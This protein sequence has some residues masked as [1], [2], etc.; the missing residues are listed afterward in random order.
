LEESRPVS[1]AILEHPGPWTEEDFLAFGPTPNRIELIDG[2]LLVSSAPRMS[3]QH[4]AR[5][6][7]NSLEPTAAASGLRVF[8]AINIRLQ[9][10]RIVVPDVVVVETNDNSTVADVAVVRFICEVVSPNNAARD[11]VLKRELYA[12][13]GI[14]W[15]L[16]ADEERDDTVTLRLY[17]LSGGRYIEHAAAM[18]GMVLAAVASFD[19][20]VD[21][22]DLPV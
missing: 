17:R 22:T 15:Y 12:E 6:L 9:K 2:D 18:N 8:E 19:V 21:T 20:R 7:A 14:E 1:V 10:G 5:R 11:R 16:V 13:A 4:I 3:H